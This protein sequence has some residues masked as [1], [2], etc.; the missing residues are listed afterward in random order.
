MRLGG[1]IFHEYK[2]PDEWLAALEIEGYRAAYCPVGLDADDDEIQA[3][4]G[5]ARA[6]DIV[7]AE[8]GAWSNPLSP[9][10]AERTAARD[11]CKQALALADKIGARCAVNI[12]GSRSR[13]SWHGPHPDDLTPETFALIV[14]M[15]REI[16]DAVQPQT[17]AYT[18][19][20]MPWMYPDSADNSLRLIEAVDR[21]PAFR[22]HLDPV[23]IVTSPQIYFN[24]GDLLREN[25]AKLAP[26]IVS[27]HAKDI[28]LRD[29]LTVHLDEV[30]LGT[31]VLDYVTFLQEMDKLEP[32]MPL[33]LEH[34]ATAD[35]YRMAATNVRRIASEVGVTM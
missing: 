12:A 33:M 7:I 26:H 10:E 15:V 29:N 16:I 27:V 35:E 13:T 21:G 24:T 4:A 32:D 1:P 28:I 11:K 25:F 2:T 18:L 23:N 34:L 9:D 6:N 14:D 20:P 3:Y 5:A 22:A 17:A 31:G 30:I 19:E 8:V